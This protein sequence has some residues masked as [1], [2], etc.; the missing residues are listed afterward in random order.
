MMSQWK[1]VPIK[2]VYVGLFD[3]PHATPKV[4]ESGPIFLG[5]K[6]VGE[7]GQL[8]FS[9]IRHISEEE[10]P[11]W[12]KRIEPKYGDIVFSYEAT[13]N[14]Y[15]IIPK[16]FRGCLG[17]RMAL[18][19][20]DESKICGRFLFHYFFGKEWRN[21][22]AQNTLIGSTVDRI[23][24]AKFPNF[25]I[26]IPPIP[27]QHKIASILSAYNDL[28]ENNTKRIKILEKM[29]QIIYNEWFVKFK[30]P[31]H[32]NVKMV[33]SEFGIIPEGWETKEYSE[34]LKS[35]TGGDWG[36][37][38]PD[39]KEMCPVK[40]IRGTDFSD[41]FYGS[42]L[43]L[44]CRY[45][46]KSSLEK[47]KLHKGDIIVENSVNAQSRC[48][49]KSLLITQSVLDRIGSDVIAAS[50]CKV[51]RLNN[52]NLAS[53][54]YL[55]LKHLYDTGKMGFY[56]NVATNGIGNFQ[57]KRFV[58]SESIPFPKGEKLLL[59]MLSCLN[60]IVSSNYAF[61]ISTLCQMR[62]HLL[63]KL[64]SGEI[65]VSELDIDVGG[66]TA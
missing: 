54:M 34:L 61:R 12:T 18:I 16:G 21:V 31:G 2:E 47:R 10:Y 50:F 22:I 41:V 20:P 64:I 57:A 28:I 17:R 25:P 3:G 38:E 62:D 32:E 65:D 7:N 40:I 52:A 43:N 59:Y 44:P 30:F 48:T 11:R 63:P 5:I 4:S 46:S 29:A 66:I 24:I 55:H 58:E 8:D 1:T 60:N 19:R 42:K 14:L 49:G 36:V 51:F 37:E 9:D 53:I 6:N 15:A 27:V 39:D 35:Y 33:E 13:L 26:T 23:P 45:I 56:Q